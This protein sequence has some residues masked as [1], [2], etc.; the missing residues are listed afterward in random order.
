[1]K[2]FKQLVKELPSNRVVIAYGRFQPPTI[3]HEHLVKAVQKVAGSTADH[4]IFT[5]I[6][7]DKKTNPLSVD[8]KTYFIK[9]MFTGCNIS[10]TASD[11][12]ID[13]AKK[14]NEKYK[15]LT[16]VT[17][18][19]KVAEYE[20][21]LKEHNGTAYQFD[22]IKVVSSGEID[23]DSDSVS[24]LSGIK[25]CESAK[26]GDL[27]QF[28]KGV[29][30]TLTELD[31]RRLMNDV[32]K[33]MG[34]EIIKEVVEFERS[35][36]RE[37]YVAGKI[38]NVGDKVKDEAGVYEIMDRG[39]NYITVVNE[40]GEM[41]KKWIDKVSPTKSKKEEPTATPNQVTFKGYTTKNFH[42]SPEATSAFQD[43]IAQHDK[44]TVNDGIAVMHALKNT[45]AF[46]HVL[47]V[48]HVHDKPASELYKSSHDK[49]KESLEKINQFQAHADYWD[50]FKNTI[51]S[52][53]A[54]HMGVQDAA[55]IKPTGEQ[56]S[57]KKLKE[58]EE[59]TTDKVMMRYKDFLK[60]ATMSEPEVEINTPE[61]SPVPA[62]AKDVPSEKKNTESDKD[63]EKKSAETPTI[64]GGLMHPLDDT[65]NHNLRRQKVNY[66]LGEGKQD[67]Y[68]TAEKHL[69]LAD[70]A[71][72]KKDMFSH[73]M[74]MADYH[75]SLSQWHDSKGRSSAAEKHA[76]KAADHEEMAHAI[77]EEVK[78]VGPVNTNKVNTAGDEPHDEKWEDAG[79]CMEH[80]KKDC[81][82]NT[83]KEE[84]IS[85]LSTNLLARY[86]TASHASAKAADQAGNYAKGDKR[87]KGINK[88]TTKQFDND[89][90]KHGQYKEDV[91]SSDTKTKKV[92]VQDKDG[93]WV[94][95]DR[96]SHPHRIDF[97]AS[98]MNGKPVG[99]SI[100]T[101]T[102]EA[103][104]LKQKSMLTKKD[105]VK[106][107]E[108]KVK[109]EDEITEAKLKKKSKELK[110]NETGKDPLTGTPPF[111]PFF[112][113][114]EITDEDI[115]Q[116]AEE[117]TWEDMLEEYEDDELEFID[118]DTGEVVELEDVPIM[119]VLSR[120]ERIR[121]K[122][123]FANTSS[124]RKRAIK[125]ALKT[126]SSIGKVNN[127]ARRLAVKLMKLRIA[128][129]PLDKLSIGE[130][131]RLEK[132]VQKRKKVLDRISMKLVARVRKVENDRLSRRKK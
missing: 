111:D 94:F 64:T 103:W 123:R 60:K 2:N 36:I 35:T 96:K 52:V 114:V 6:S 49:A 54:K 55:V 73:H 16:L 91:Y 40:S 48:M 100:I 120:A 115:D 61:K 131:E 32:R 122:I 117:L 3:A 110:D 34:L 85:E 47:D 77:K 126:R 87:F 90:K 92:Q 33:G 31:A 67:H 45:D 19:D 44:G 81:G 78:H 107:E 21:Q 13:V 76:M 15:T 25:M 119:E 80:G 105:G 62:K 10:E 83:V 59:I 95:K 128:K 37:K 132:I 102:F 89:L 113:D 11:S 29:P 7:E 109:P 4:F 23:P 22:T 97:E 129:R 104:V 53:I 127:R 66:H 18:S 57:G 86:K 38:F 82:C 108:P 106:K 30:H 9:R 99:E 88:A 28:K 41:S 24:A 112:E 130:K 43:T 116:Y 69:S 12:I 50:K 93:N 17:G 98:R 58:S 46:L 27:D 26:A 71:Q 39:A 51:D 79:I 101:Q 118:E 124:K 70:K 63:A 42:H 8:R 65:Q 5:S 74:H 68:D 56:M 20:K 125:I 1:M 14:L 121:S 75:D 72:D 84:T